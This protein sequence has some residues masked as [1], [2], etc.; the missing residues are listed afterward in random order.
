MSENEVQMMK[1]LLLLYNCLYLQSGLICQLQCSPTEVNLADRRLVML[2]SESAV[3]GKNMFFLVISLR[4]QSWEAVVGM[5]HACTGKMLQQQ[6]VCNC[7]CV[8][9][10]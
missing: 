9:V 1:K 3:L 4:G 5:N 8:A 6:N 2:M 10:P 7:R